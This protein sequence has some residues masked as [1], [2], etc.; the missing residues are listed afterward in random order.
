MLGLLCLGCG[1]LLARAAGA[2][3]GAA[4]LLPCGFAVIVVVSGLATALPATAP[5]AA[6]VIVGL[7]VVGLCLL[8]RR[9]PG[10]DA[11]AVAAV[12]ATTLLLFGAPVLLSGNPTFA[13]YVKLDDTATF[14]AFADHALQHGRDLSS[15]APSS[16]EA[17][18]AVNVANGYPLGSILP[19]GIG[20]NL[21]DTDP[22]WVW[23]PFI[24]FAAAL[25]AMTLYGLATKLVPSRG[26]RAAVALV[27][28]QSALLYGYALWGGVKEVVGAALLAL[29]A[30]TL[31]HA[32][33]RRVRELLVPATAFAAFLG[34]LSL[35][36]GPWLVLP[37]AAVLLAPGLQRLRRAVVFCSLLVLLAIPALAESG[38]FLRHAN[39]SSFRSA[40]ELGNLARPLR[41]WQVLGV[42]PTG[43]FRLDPQ[44]RW[45]AAGLVVIALA[46]VALGVAAAVRRGSWPLL[47]LAAAAAVSTAVFVAASSPWVAGKALAIASPVALFLAA[48]GYAS[49][50]ARRR[51]PVA[52]VLGGLLVTGVAW[53]NV[54]AYH[55]VWLAPYD[56]LSELEHIGQ[57]FAGQG[58]AL[59]SEYQPYGVRHFLRRLD[60]EGASELRRHTVPLANGSFLQKGAY[61]DI[62]EFLLSSLTRDYRLLVLRRSPVA[63]RPSSVYKLVFRG[64]WYDVWR[65]IDGRP[66]VDHLALRDPLSR[67][68]VPPCNTV[69]EMAAR[70]ERDGASLVTPEATT[71][72]VVGLDDHLPLGWVSAGP[73]SGVVVGAG[74]GTT[75]VTANLHAAGTFGVWVGGSTRAHVDARV[76]GVRVGSTPPHINQSGM[77]IRLGAVALGTGPHEVTLSLTS[78]GFRPG[79]GGD[80]FYLGPVALAQEPTGRLRTVAAADGTS[81]CGV[82]LDWL[83]ATALS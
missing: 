31:V 1:V 43:D 54:L 56:Q 7:A 49:L 33:R 26:L 83:E 79:S 48:C 70:A 58:P 29:S 64:N 18:L 27:G 36:G 19:L 13:G 25:L 5:F 57:R 52:L 37:G 77:W 3:I 71:S 53:S 34:V 69:R 32:Q 65:R 61:A 9:R 75:T 8:P 17:T 51:R 44:H 15:L 68:A 21:V 12:G 14:L 63:S 41:L 66:T 59:M 23:Q 82:S 20:A 73:G 80:G 6:P 55:A 28:A 76:D 81:L 39:V 38:A 78:E 24:S 40:S 2:A 50:L 42:W 30:A 4:I 22:A 16:Y 72:V 35:G 47:A 74:S 46:G 10:R 45:V 60:A 62:D 67:S 11:R